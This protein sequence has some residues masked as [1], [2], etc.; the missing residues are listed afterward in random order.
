MQSVPTLSRAGSQV[1]F[2]LFNSTVERPP[3]PPAL[4]KAAED[5][6]GY[7]VYLRDIID[8][9]Q[10][11]VYVKTAEPI[12]NEWDRWHVRAPV[13]S[14]FGVA[15]EVEVAICEA[16]AD[17]TVSS[18]LR[19]PSGELVMSPA[20]NASNG[21]KL[22]PKKGGKSP[23]RCEKCETPL[24]SPSPLRNA[25]SSAPSAEEPTEISAVAELRG[26]LAKT[27]FV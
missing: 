6:Q 5:D 24:R 19:G 2:N 15:T 8:Q 11:R 18:L 21:V 9:G 1:S 25:A 16:R 10:K 27:R 7:P 4:Q 17:A 3:S 22:K 23:K 12:V 14:A 20:K 26:Q 13:P